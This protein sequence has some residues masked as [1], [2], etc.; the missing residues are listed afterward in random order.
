[1][2]VTQTGSGSGDAASAAL[3]PATAQVTKQ[4][5][6]DTTSVDGTL[7]YGDALDVMGSLPGVLTW[8]PAEG[9]TVSRGQALYRV[10]D[11]PVVLLYGGMPP[12][13]TLATGVRDGPDVRQLEENLEALGYGGGFTVDDTYTGSTAAAVQAWQQDLGLP[14][15]GTVEAGR[16]VAAAGAVRVSKHEMQAGGQVAPG[17]PVIAY[18][19]TARIVTAD[20]NVSDARLAGKGGK[21]TVELPDGTRVGGTVATVGKVAQLPASD[22]SGGAPVGGATTTTD[23][24]AGDAT[25]EVTVTLDDSKGAGSL[26]QA[27]VDV[28]FVSERREG[29]LTVPVAALLALAEGGYGVEV[30]EDGTSRVVAVEVG[31]FAGGRVEVRGTGIAAGTTVGVPAS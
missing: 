19:G 21:V 31:L 24:A 23:S 27:P 14:R 10:D 25:I 22:I 26:D 12:Y 2:F 8:L 16:V 11:R 7:G 13:R 28:E 5:L 15:T 6:A 30:V 18:T 20:L 1:L 3:P 29:V 17:Q 9:S 4:N